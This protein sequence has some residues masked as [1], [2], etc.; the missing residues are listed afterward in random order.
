MKTNKTTKPHQS[1]TVLLVDDADNL[2]IVHKCLLCYFGYKVDAMRCAEDALLFFKPDVHKIVMTDN[3]M[4]QMTGLQMARILKTKSPTT[5]ILMYTSNP[6]VDRSC[7]DA[8]I[9]KPTHFLMVIEALER[10]LAAAVA[11]H[12]NPTEEKKTAKAN[13]QCCDMAS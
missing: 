4:P 11:T 10:L 12:S 9:Q 1:T 6:P 5:P 7:V 2:R 13:S 8:V 3:S